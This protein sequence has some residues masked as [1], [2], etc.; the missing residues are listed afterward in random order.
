[1]MSVSVPSDNQPM[2]MVIDDDDTAR[3]MA[4]GFLAQSGFQVSEAADGVSALGCVADIAPD[5]IL[6]DVE[7]PGMDGFEVCT[8]LRSMP[9]F[10]HTPIMMLTGL[11]DDE[12]IDKAYVAG[13]TDFASKPINWSL[14]CHRLR[15]MHRTSLSAEQLVRE[16][17]SLAE[18]Q[19]IAQI[20]SW[21]FDYSL[22]STVC[23]DQT[24]RI[25]GVEPDEVEPSLDFMLQYVHEDDQERVRQYFAQVRES[26][27]TSSIDHQLKLLDGTIRTV[28]QKVEPEF[29]AD[30][31]VIGLNAIVQDFTKRREVEEKVHRLAYYDTLTKLPNRILFQ[32]QLELAMEMAN[33]QETQLAV[34]YFDLDDFKRVNDTFG[35]GTGD[36]LLHE[37]GLRLG[38]SLRISRKSPVVASVQNSIARMGGDEFTIILNNV[39]HRSDVETVAERIIRVVSKPYKIDGYELFTSPSIGIALYPQDGLNADNL[40]QNADMAMYEAKRTGKSMYML[41]NEE[42]RANASKRHNIDIQMRAA[43]END[44]FSVHYQVQ[45]D[46]STGL[47]FSA[48]ALARWHSDVLGFVSPADFIPVAEDNGMII[49]I[50][51]WILQKSCLQAKQ[52]IDDGFQVP[53]VAVNISAMQFMRTDFPNVVCKILEECDLPAERLELEI[54]ES[55]LASDIKHAIDTLEKLNEIGVT[56]S[57]DDFGT[58]Y[59]SLSQLK[60]FPIDRLKIDQS[61]IRNITEN[62]DDAAITC[63]VIAMSKSMNIK[64]LAEGVETIEQLQFLRDNGCNEIQG[65]FISK[66]VAASQ[67]LEDMPQLVSHLEELFVGDAVN[68]QKSA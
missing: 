66:P 34:L 54:T 15:Y 60:H 61:F 9:A 27:G 39:T 1:M 29:N 46:L 7:M 12:Y 11:E 28:R 20:G 2:V 42:M 50:G 58:G 23:S 44:E 52:W 26:S 43:L 10:S 51:E 13:A 48:E 25:F 8:T 6:L 47:I 57:I 65:Y 17:A 31:K 68:V 53:R 56:L 59:S 16:Q 55:L 37:V 45:I 18:A 3:M 40:L 36:K 22:K 30:G 49:T 38:E 33:L 21:Q 35:H 14:L 62:Q 4:M 5:L 63:A 24:Y 32:E 64:V 41:H 19:R 67:L